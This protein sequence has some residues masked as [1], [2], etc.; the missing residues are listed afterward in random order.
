MIRLTGI[1]FKQI[2]N[3]DWKR[4][5]RPPE[6]CDLSIEHNEF[7]L[8]GEELDDYDVDKILD[9]DVVKIDAVICDNNFSGYL[10]SFDSLVRKWR[11][12]Q[13]FTSF[14]VTVKQDKADELKKLI[15]QA[16]GTI[17]K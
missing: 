17:S 11:K 15:K 3:S 16:G 14:V 7:V 4:I 2:Y 8:N 12:M 1:E 10:V 9:T 5:L 6:D 13:D